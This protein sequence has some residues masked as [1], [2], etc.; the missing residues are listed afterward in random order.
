MQLKSVGLKNSGQKQTD[1]FPKNDT[2]KIVYV[3]FVYI[4]ENIL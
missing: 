3:T 2:M 4:L 1:D